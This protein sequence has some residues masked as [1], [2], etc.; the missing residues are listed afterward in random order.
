MLVYFY[1]SAYKHRAATP[2]ALSMVRS[3]LLTVT[4]ISIY[5]VLPLLRKKPD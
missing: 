2:P 1:F 5:L 4:L 3:L